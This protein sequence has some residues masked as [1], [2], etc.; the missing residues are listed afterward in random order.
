MAHSAL[1]DRDY[2]NQK[3]KYNNRNE[4]RTR[5]APLIEIGCGGLNPDN[6]RIMT[7]QSL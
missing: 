7:L 4:Q 2:E 1:S 5:T 6:G 3:R